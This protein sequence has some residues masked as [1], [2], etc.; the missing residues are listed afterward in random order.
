ME[1]AVQDAFVLHEIA[2][3]GTRVTK[4]IYKGTPITVFTRNGRYFD[5]HFWEIYFDEEDKKYYLIYEL[6]QNEEDGYIITEC[7]LDVELSDV[8]K[9][10]TLSYIAKS[11]KRL[12]GGA[13]IW[14]N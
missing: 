9:I 2:N 6:I 4:V 7:Y 5:G 11:E 13:M 3:D 8:V 1:Y 12:S 10:E 14:Q